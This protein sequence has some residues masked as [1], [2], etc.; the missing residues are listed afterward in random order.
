MNN[1]IFSS[2]ALAS[3]FYLSIVISAVAQSNGPISKEF[4]RSGIS[5]LPSAMTK[6]AIEQLNTDRFITWEPSKDP[7]RE[8]VVDQK[9]LDNVGREK[10]TSGASGI[11]GSQPFIVPN[12]VIIQFKPEVTQAEIKMYLDENKYNVIQTFPSIGAV[13]IQVDLSPFFKP[14]LS[15]NDPN[16]ALLRGV[17]TAAAAFKMDERV[18]YAAPDVALTSKSAPEIEN[19]LSPT[20]IFTVSTATPEIADWGIADIEADQLWSMAGADNGA[21]FGVMDVGFGRHEDIIFIGPN[22]NGEADN[23]GNHVA[24]IGCAKHNNRG[25]RGVLPNCFVRARSA[26]VFFQAAQGNPQLRF[27]TFFSQILTTLDKFVRE[28]DDIKTF[29]VSLGYNWRSNFGINPDLP[30]SQQWRQLVEMQGP[31]L[32]ALLEAA[33][34][35]GKVIF[36]AAGNDSTGLDTPISAKYASPFNW[37]AITAREQ[38]IAQNGVIVAA[39]DPNGN[40]ASFSN[41][42]ADISCPGTNVTSALAFDENG[43]PSNSV[44]GTMSGTSMA[45]P[46]CAAGHVLFQL[47]RAEGYN[48]V[49]AVQCMLASNEATNDGVPMLKL[50]Q[51]LSACPNL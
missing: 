46:Y 27:L 22:Q 20:D 45:S 23:H 21:I 5:L 35:R 1:K 28:Q 24:A 43:D 39:H 2:L 11:N 44:Y 9:K 34:K 4:K 14:S 38:G 8:V 31:L 30:E 3:G 37:A 41:K 18:Q 51:A 33:D 10:I 32:V 17:A 48:A 36:S 29:N 42:D 6:S 26:D 16:S 49:E 25:V 7:A 12:S 40:R 13:Q 19:V 50:T 47:V 15:D